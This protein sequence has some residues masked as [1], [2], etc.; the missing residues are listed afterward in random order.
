MTTDLDRLGC[1]AREIKEITNDRSSTEQ[2]EKYWKI[3]RRRAG[4]KADDRRSK[5][6]TEL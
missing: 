5:A 4:K 1:S 2:V 3:G 6:I